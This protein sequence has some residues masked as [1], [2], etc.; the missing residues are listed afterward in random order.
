MRSPALPNTCALFLSVMTACAIQTCH[1]LLLLLQTEHRAL[2][3]VGCN[4]GVLTM[5]LQ[6]PPHGQRHRLLYALHGLHRAVA[7]LAGH[8]RYNVL[9]VIEIDK[10]KKVVDLDL[11]NRTL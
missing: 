3:V 6:A 8:A 5:A 11:F 4:L 2:K 7:A 1:G 9:N 10:V